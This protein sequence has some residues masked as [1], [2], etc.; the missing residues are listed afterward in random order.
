MKKQV[1]RTFKIT[2][3]LALVAIFAV[4][5]LAA[6]PRMT[7]EDLKSMLDN[8]DVVVLD[9]RTG[10]DWKASE[11]KIKGAVREDATDFGSWAT[12]YPKDKTLVL[13]CA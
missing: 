6:V 9:V 11:T 5:A 2:V 12:K 7:K 4:S 10:K 1:K 13:Y 8:P 3:S